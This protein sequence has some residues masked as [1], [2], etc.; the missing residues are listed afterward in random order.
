MTK[1]ERPAGE[2]PTDKGAAPPR[3]RRVLIA[4]VAFVFAVVIAT[5]QLTKNWATANL[6]HQPPIPIIDGWVS[7]LFYR[8]GGAAFGMGAGATWLF[9]VVAAAVVVVIVVTARKLGSTGWAISFG[10]LL[11]GAGGNLTDRLFRQP[12]FGEGKVVDFINLHF[13]ICNVADIAITAGAVLFI[14]LSFMGIGLDGTRASARRRE[15]S[16]DA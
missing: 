12:G 3:R 10:L 16:G 4:V 2:G 15:E 14:L 11:A 6:E 7:L 8:N 9:A 5:D 13:F 1:T